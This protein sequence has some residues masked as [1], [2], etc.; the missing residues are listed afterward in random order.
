MSIDKP[1]V[2][3]QIFFGNS[4]SKLC[5]RHLQSFLVAF[6]Q[7]VQNIGKSKASL[8]E[9]VSCFATVKAKIQEKQSDAHIKPS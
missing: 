1:P 9:L 4:L 5:L 7:H 3:L 2:V 6:N 8:V